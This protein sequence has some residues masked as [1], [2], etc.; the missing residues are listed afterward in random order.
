MQP[1]GLR[2]EVRV[3]VLPQ[4]CARKGREGG[5]L[6]WGRDRHKETVSAESEGKATRLGGSQT[7]GTRAAPHSSGGEGEPGADRRRRGT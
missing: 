2:E 4:A 6:A 5:Q 3:G 1:R 7:Q